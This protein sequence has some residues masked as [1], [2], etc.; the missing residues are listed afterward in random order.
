[1]PAKLHGGMGIPNPDVVYMY[2]EETGCKNLF[3]AVPV[4]VGKAA[5]RSPEFLKKNPTGEVPVLELED[6]TFLSESISISLLLDEMQGHTSVVGKTHGERALTDMWIRRVE[7]KILNPM[8]MKFQ[9]G[10]MNAFFKDRRPGYIHAEIVEPMKAATMA[11]FS[12]LNDQFADGRS[13]LCGD[14]FSLADIRF[15]CLYAFFS[16]MDKDLAAPANLTHFHKYADRLK[17]RPSAVAIAPK[18][19][20]KM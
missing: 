16:K 6:G 15:H 20:S 19:K 14:R 7:S 8:G 5:N 18:P 11:G 9:S 4:D 3:E 1:M 12:W 2:A 10:K 17:S 13:F